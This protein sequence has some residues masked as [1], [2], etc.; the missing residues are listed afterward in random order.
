MVLPLKPDF[1]NRDR[2]SIMNRI[3]SFIIACFIFGLLSPSLEAEG[4]SLLFPP[5]KPE[6]VILEQYDNETTSAQIVSMSRSL[7]L[8]KPTDLTHQIRFLTPDGPLSL[9]LDQLRTIHFTEDQLVSVVSDP[10]L[11][12]VRSLIS[13]PLSSKDKS[14]P[15][16]EYD[17]A[18]WE[19][20]ILA[21]PNYRWFYIPGA[22][23]IWVRKGSYRS[24][25][26]ETLLIRQRFTLPEKWEP[27]RATLSITVDDTLHQ[28]FLNG[29]K[30]PVKDIRMGHDYISLDVS[31]LLEGENCLALKVS[32][33]REEALSFAGMAFRID[34]HGHASGNPALPSPPGA[35]VFLENDDYLFGD[36]VGLSDRSVKVIAHDAGIEIDRDWI[37]RI[38]LNI[39]PLPKKSRKNRSIFR[40][41]FGGG[42]ASP[43]QKSYQPFTFALHPRDPENR[44]GLLLKTGEFLRGRILELD[45]RKVVIKPRYGHDFS[46]DVGE[47]HS[48]YP[49]EPGRR[50]HLKYKRELLPRRCR[51]TMKDGTALSGLLYDI[52][53]EFLTLKPPWSPTL[54]VKNGLLTACDF[55]YSPTARLKRKLNALSPDGRF[56]VALIGENNP[57]GPS[58][59]ESTYYRI[60]CLLSEL[61]ME[62]NLLSPEEM[63]NPEIFSTERIT[64][65]INLDETESYY[66]TVNKTNDGYHALLN[67]VKN[68]GFLAHLGI[69]SPAYYG[70]EP[71]NNHWTRTV[72]PPFLNESLKMKILNPGIVGKNALPFELPD[73][74]VAGLHFI[75]NRETPFSE[76]LPDRIEFPYLPDTRFRPIIADTT[77]TSTRFVPLYWL[78]S[79]GGMNYGAAM[80]VIDYRGHGFRPTRTFYVHHLLFSSSYH[81]H[82]AIHYILPKILTLT[83]SKRQESEKEPSPCG[84]KPTP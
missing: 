13:R 3:L 66:K 5:A 57:K 71:R 67:F 22:R 49:N 83:L 9:E 4:T 60:Q 52:D 76:G 45:G 81:S 77:T 11:T 25:L 73:N 72:T 21:H 47:I 82:S 17:D 63:V 15:D 51:L 38:R 6:G 31:L 62:G 2:Q 32:K 74:R 69:G 65:V 79:E 42:G 20:P 43:R 46:V 59:E 55:P 27:R 7:E 68:G 78:Q 61:D 28:A 40:K 19:R 29:H 30:L 18:D 10:A 58:Y 33:G 56:N 80:A 14:W 36:L 41:I 53:Q 75:R 64:L 50:T 44:I 16:P 37:R 26:S 12:L 35:A 23:W 8:E 54:R 70:L 1:Q 24:P 34:I 84:T 39:D 48:I